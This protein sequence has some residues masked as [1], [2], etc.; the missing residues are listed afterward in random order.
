MF[1][2]GLPGCPSSCPFQQVGG[3]R[4][5]TN[6]SQQRPDAVIEIAEN[7][8]SFIQPIVRADDVDQHYV[9][10]MDQTPVPFNL[11]PRTTLEVEGTATVPIRRSGNS[12]VRATCA[13]AVTADGFKLPPMLI[14]KGEKNGRIASKEL[15]FYP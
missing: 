11:S 1:L 3:P 14:F 8:F 10:N 4:R 5:R 15:P 7:W 2:E 9:I 12:T 6:A 13:L